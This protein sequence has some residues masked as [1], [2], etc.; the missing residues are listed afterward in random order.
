MGVL[1]R[2]GLIVFAVL[3]VAAT[4][5]AIGVFTVHETVLSASFVTD[6]AD[7]ADVYDRIE[8]ELVATAADEIQGAGTGEI[9]TTVLNGRTIA[10]EAIT[11]AYV[12][13]QS[14]QVIDAGVGYL[15]GERDE[16]AL[17]VDTRPLA[18][19]ASAAAG[20]AVRDVDLAGL[21][22]RL[23][24]DQIETF[25][26]TDV[27]VSGDTLE[28]MRS[29]PAEYDAAGTEFRAD[30]RAAAIDQVM[31]ERSAAE[32][33]VLIGIEPPEDRTEREQL[34][35]DNEA[36]IRAAIAE[37]P[38]FQ[39]EFDD[40]L[41][42]LRAEVATTIE[43][44]TERATAGYDAEITEPATEMQLAVLDG[45]VTDQ[46]Y[47]Q[48][49]E[50]IERS[51]ATIADEAER[52][53]R[54]EIEAALDDEVDLTAE[55][56]EE[57]RDQIDELAVAV[58]LSELAG[59]GLLGAIVLLTGLAYGVSR[60]IDATAATTGSGLLTGGVVAVLVATQDGRVVREIEAEFAG[61]TEP[62]AEAAEAFA[63]GVVEG[64]SGQLSAYGLVAVLGG[65]VLLGAVAVRRYGRDR[66]G[67]P[68]KHDPEQK[69]TQAPAEDSDETGGGPDTDREE[70]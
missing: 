29:G 2:V 54:S 23:G 41:A 27:P 55:L 61:E 9:P 45:L 39:A 62:L 8:S 43:T 34:V 64:V 30:V 42:T 16:L 5:G 19:N 7:E 35:A 21:V 33:L 10:D 69:H 49:T 56:S 17:V 38:Q 40:Q 57:D 63:V 68:D 37:D 52:I 1:G 22:E 4:V 59:V 70:S 58:Q 66:P 13:T 24:A 11:E 32:L 15:R 44:E 31:A 26:G 67:E 6:T 50:R 65:T 47:E 60:S 3:V 18:D 36:E 25:V 46:S 48:F 20:A 14:E 12:R 51:Q 28:R 53:A